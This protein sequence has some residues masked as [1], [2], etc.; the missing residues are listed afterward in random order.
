MQK[1]T[2]KKLSI[3]GLVLMAASAVTAAI[4]P[5]SKPAQ[6]AFSL[7]AQTA[8]GAASTESCMPTDAAEL[9]P[10]QDDSATAGLASGSTDEDAQGSDGATTV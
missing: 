9:D 1:V 4:L 3:L 6:T 10:C 5:N 8:D 7:S 2:F